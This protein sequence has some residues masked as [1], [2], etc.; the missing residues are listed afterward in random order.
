MGRSLLRRRT[1]TL[2]V[3]FV[4]LLLL[5]FRLSRTS[6]E[7]G[8]RAPDDVPE[9]TRDAD[10][11]DTA[12]DMGMEG[13]NES[14]QIGY[15]TQPLRNPRPDIHPVEHLSQTAEHEFRA[16]L[17]RQSKTLEEAVKEY[18]RRYKLAPPPHFDKWVE[19][20]MENK[21]Q[22]VDEFDTIHELMTPFWGLSPRTIRSRAQEALGRDNGLLGIAIRGH[23]VAFVDNA[24]GPE[25][26]QE[27]TTDMMA[28]FLQYLPDMDL[29]FNIHDEPRV[30]L[31][32]D[33][34]ARL[35]RKATTEDMVSSF[36]NPRPVNAFATSVPDLEATRFTKVKRTRFRAAAH[37]P[38]WTTSRMSC[39]PDSAARILD[40]ATLGDDAAR[41]ALTE[42]GFV[43]NST[44]LAD[45]CLSPSLSQTHGFF[46]RPNGYNVAH[47]L[48]PIF[49]QSK[50]SSYS[51]I[52]YP[53]PWYWSGKVTYNEAKDFSWNDKDAQLY[54]RGS[55]TGGFGRDGSWKRH[56]RQR[57]VQKLTHAPQADVLEMETV[58]GGDQTHEAPSNGILRQVKRSEVDALLNVRFS[59]VGQCDPADC[60]AQIK[61]FGVKD[62]VDMNDAWRYRFLLDMDGNAFSGRF[63]ALLQS[64]S[65]VFK[66][67]IF[68]EWH[69][70]R[71]KPWVHYVPMSMRGHDWVELV[72]FYSSRSNTRAEAMARASSDWAGKTLRKV[73]MEAWFFRLLLEY[74]RVVDDDRASIGFD[75]SSMDHR[76][77]AE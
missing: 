26:Q 75:L 24:H 22:L 63:Y 48:F 13:E 43:A 16:T 58:G 73:D 35:V 49:S 27:A 40:D 38:T 68:Q 64:R 69:R 11:L 9:A 60:Q 29:A 30:V 32:H 62:M 17:D 61:H 33:D 74:A 42:A 6:L 72:R 23:K 8:L 36:A 4:S 54:W 52:I 56:H 21:V 20:A 47:D 31:Q 5:L 59:H 65:Q 45:I 25:W 76:P 70:E 53:S 28:K 39:P 18:R 1:L 46:D 57:L 2:V 37:Q 44:A 3:V 41:Y 34:L 14:H 55:T 12:I 15:L 71:L 19:F 10:P 50:M 51:D 77:A 66:Q 67:A 7:Y